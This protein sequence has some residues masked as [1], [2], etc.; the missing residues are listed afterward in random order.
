MFAVTAAPRTHR[1][2]LRL[3]LLSLGPRSWVSFEAAA[4]LHGLDRSDTTAVEFTIPRVGRRARSQFT[5]HTTKRLNRLDSVSV[6]GLRAISATRT[7]LDLALSRSPLSRVEA[8]IDSAVRLG[9]SSPEVIA[10]RLTTLRGSGR[11]GVRMIDVLLLDSGG[12][13]PLERQ[14]LALVRR[15]RLPTPRTQVVHRK[16]G[17]HIAR[18][19]FLFDDANVIVEVTGRLGHSTPLDRDRDAQRRNELQDLGL[20]VYE[21]TAGDVRDRS[22]MVIRTLRQRLAEASLPA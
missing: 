4:A 3:G 20:K 1:Q 5:V 17:R 12:H 2:Q 11:W 10:R 16:G 8:A 19:D 22:E 15:A 21:Y 14:F 13:S 18:V 6:H 9:L 7:I